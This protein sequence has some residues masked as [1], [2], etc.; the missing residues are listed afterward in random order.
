[1]SY[2]PQE[3]KHKTMGHIE[4]NAF[5][6]ERLRQ[7]EILGAK[8]GTHK[9]VLSPVT[10]VFSYKLKKICTKSFLFRMSWYKLLQDLIYSKVVD[11]TKSIIY[12][13]CLLIENVNKCASQPLLFHS[14]P[15]GV[16]ENH[17]CRDVFQM[18]K[19]IVFLE[20]QYSFMHHSKSTKH[21]LALFYSMI[22]DVDTSV[23]NKNSK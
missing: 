22:D 20:K 10:F 16:K 15:Y 2:G 9:L 4:S 11:L 13:C 14:Q 23:W 3:T 21:N 1:M 7:L 12:L 5:P 17:K 6:S 8:H 18:S 19:K